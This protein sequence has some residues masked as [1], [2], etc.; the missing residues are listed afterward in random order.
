MPITEL[1]RQ[2]RLKNYVLLAVL[3]GLAATLVA[4]T[5]IRMGA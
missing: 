2:K 1:H 5:M 3:L 4:M